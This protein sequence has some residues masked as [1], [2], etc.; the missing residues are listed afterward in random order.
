MIDSSEKPNHHL[1]FALQNS[2][3]R[4]KCSIKL[5]LMELD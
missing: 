5:N 4:E 2:H 3:V 1:A